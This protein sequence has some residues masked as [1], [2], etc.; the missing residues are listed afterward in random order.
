MKVHIAIALALFVLEQP[1]DSHK[2]SPGLHTHKHPASLV[3]ATKGILKGAAKAA[4]A[5]GPV[6][7]YYTS[8]TLSPYTLTAQTQLT[9]TTASSTT[10]VS[11]ADVTVSFT[12]TTVQPIEGFGASMTESAAYLF[13][14]LSSSARSAVFTNLFDPM[15]GIGLNFIRA[16]IG[17]NDLTLPY[18]FYTLDD[19]SSADT[20]LSKFSITTDKKYILP[21]LK[22]AYTIN[23][24]LEILGT[25]WSPPAWMKTGK[26]LNGSTGGS[27]QSKYY[28]AYAQYFVDYV[29]D[30]KS[31]GVPI[32]GLTVQNEPLYAPSGYPGMILQATDSATFINSYLGPALKSASLSTKILAYDHNWDQPSYPQTVLSKASK[33]VS[34]VAWHCYAGDAATA[35]KA[36]QKSNPG[37]PQYMT[38]CTGYAAEDQSK[39]LENWMGLMV[40]ILQNYG[41]GV[42]RWTF[43]QD[44][45]YHPCLSTES[46]CCTCRGVVEVDTTA[47]SSNSGAPVVTG[48]VKY[49]TDFYGLGHFSKFVKRGA[50]KY[51]TVMTPASSSTNPIPQVGFQNP[52]GTIAVVLVNN[53]TSAINFA[54][55]YSAYQTNVATIPAHTAATFVFNPSGASSAVSG[56]KKG[57][58]VI[59]T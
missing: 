54:M 31:A 33:Y 10:S 7:N 29:K 48:V 32:W 28:S 40:H 14:K 21:R 16:P 24:S 41:R 27:L 12:G 43:A 38:E 26:N 55:I 42:M 11:G 37:I 8:E 59:K 17:S 58:S 46:S 15:N 13:S 39:T 4:T 1:V 23:P 49:N 36:V 5:P 53:G 30:Y 2:H 20:S 18:H 52:D 50:Y 25:P 47:A 56:Y 45:Q 6:A 9:W 19:S 3:N 35:Q 57:Q 34:G 44:A 22:D 51:S